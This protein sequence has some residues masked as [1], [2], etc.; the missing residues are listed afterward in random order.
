MIVIDENT[1]KQTIVDLLIP[2]KESG[3]GNY[4]YKKG[5]RGKQM[6]LNSDNQDIREQM[7]A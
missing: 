4:N 1:Q 2:R 7:F 3:L 5:K 6:D